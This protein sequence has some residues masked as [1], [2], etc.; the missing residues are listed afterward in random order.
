MPGP[1]DHAHAGAEHVRPNVHSPVKIATVS[2][3]PGAALL[4]LTRKGLLVNN[5]FLRW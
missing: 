4:D 3:H 5:H 2:W 1:Y